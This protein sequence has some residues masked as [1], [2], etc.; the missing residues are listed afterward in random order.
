MDAGMLTATGQF[1]A[2][3]DGP[4]EGSGAVVLQSSVAR[5]NVPLRIHGTLPDLT[6]VGHK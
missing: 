6:A 2:E 1:V 4:L 3:R 5:A